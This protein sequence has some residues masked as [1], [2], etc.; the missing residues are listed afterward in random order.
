M[1]DLFDLMVNTLANVIENNKVT[2]MLKKAHSA[3]RLPGVKAL[4]LI[5]YMALG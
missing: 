2:I 3:V 1:E 4:P 5:K